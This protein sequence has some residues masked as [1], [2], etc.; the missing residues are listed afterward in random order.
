MKVCEDS[1]FDKVLEP[2]MLCEELLVGSVQA[3]VLVSSRFQPVPT[4]PLQIVYFCTFSLFISDLSSLKTK[5]DDTSV[6]LNDLM[7]FK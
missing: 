4:K 5:N 2:G 7:A 1:T 6:K 3:R